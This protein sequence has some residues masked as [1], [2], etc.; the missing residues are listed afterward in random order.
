MNEYNRI[1]AIKQIQDK[2]NDTQ[3]SNQPLPYIN[4][5]SYAFSNQIIAH[6]DKKNTNIEN[7]VSTNLVK[8]CRGNMIDVIK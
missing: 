7:K 5:D 2:P 8:K 4:F 1:N 6:D 3:Q